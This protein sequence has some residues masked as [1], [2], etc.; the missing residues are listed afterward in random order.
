MDFSDVLKKEIFT[1]NRSDFE[2]Y[3]LQTFY[4]QANANA[5]Y[6]SYL[7]YLKVNPSK[8]TT[9]EAIP[10]LPIEFFKT[11]EVISGNKQ[12]ATVFESSGTTGQR[13]SKHFVADT[14]FYE[15]ISTHIFES[16]FGP[17][18]EFSFLALLP[19]Y[20]E[21]QGSSLIYMVR[22]FIAKSANKEVKFYLHDFDEM[23]LQIADN[24]A[25]GI[26]NILIGVSFALL[27]LAELLQPNL[28]NTIVI[29]TGGMKGRRT[30]IVRE[31]LHEQLNKSFNTTIIGSEY[32]MTELL[33]QAY[34]IQHGEFDSPSWMKIML[35]NPSDPFEISAAIK[36]GGINIIDLANIDSC[37]F[38]ETK[39]L[40]EMLPNGTFRVLGRFDNSEIRGCN[41]LL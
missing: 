13:R 25:N 37:A 6:A 12:G 40:G 22:H 24:E 1:I 39:D 28:R 4:Y 7:K 31:A 32:G 11:H 26:K 3:A 19:S 41:L 16:F 10:F 18:S 17:L 5:V 30:E 35:R 9:L 8:I 2:E 14:E 21:R 15:K 34:A 27:D 29:E 33:S 36:R 20:A 38:I 23:L